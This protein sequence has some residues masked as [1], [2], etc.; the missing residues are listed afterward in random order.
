LP[1]DTPP[2]PPAPPSSPATSAVSS[3]AVL[4]M[5][6]TACACECL[7]GRRQRAKKREKR[8][9]LHGGGSTRSVVRSAAGC[10]GPT[11]LLVSC[12]KG[13]AH[14]SAKEGTAGSRHAA[15]GFTCCSRAGL[16]PNLQAFQQCLR[17]Q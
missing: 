13:A 7:P 1:S 2:P 6:A 8:R 5:A 14:G 3:P 12:C 11:W 17:C 16:V 4:A 9:R 15:W 10:R